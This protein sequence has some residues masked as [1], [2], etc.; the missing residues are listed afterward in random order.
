M[1][2]M[3]ARRRPSPPKACYRTLPS[4]NIAASQNGALSGLN[5][6]SVA[7]G[8]NGAFTFQ[9][10]SGSAACTTA[11]FGYDPAPGIAK[12]CYTD[13]LQ[14]PIAQDSQ[15]FSWAGTVLYGSGL[16]GNYLSL[17]S[18]GSR[19]CTIAT[20]GGDPDPFTFKHCYGISIIP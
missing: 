5:Q 12:T 18:S 16:D 17:S 13:P 14:R 2:A 15:T 20:F 9:V 8:A 3:P 1:F 10:L 7:Y 19:A 11:T 6:T 4:Y